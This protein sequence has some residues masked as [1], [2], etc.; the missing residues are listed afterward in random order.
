MHLDST[1]RCLGS[2][3]IHKNQIAMEG[4]RP[5]H[6]VTGGSP[7]I[8][9]FNSRAAKAG[10]MPA[11]MNATAAYQRRWGDPVLS[12]GRLLR[13]GQTWATSVLTTFEELC[14]PLQPPPAE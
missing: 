13:Y 3:Y 5:R 7:S 6:T 14:A 11:M 10:A 12:A 9:H 2:A 8:V 4:G 1:F